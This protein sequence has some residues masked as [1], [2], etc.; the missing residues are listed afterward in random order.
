MLWTVIAGAAAGGVLGGALTH[1]KFRRALPGIILGAC[2]G[3]GVCHFAF[4]GP[5]P[6]TAAHTVDAFRAKVLHADKPVLVDFYA[7]WCPPCRQLSP[8]IEELAEEY[9]GRVK[10]VK[11][12]FDK[13]R[14]LAARYGV[15]G[16]PLVMFF[17]DGQPVGEVCG[18]HPKQ[19]YC[20]VLDLLLAQ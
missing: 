15:R 13:G 8:R 14:A 3:V 6:V 4:S 17:K 10:V 7:D 12:N 16:I 2:I 9:R 5:K 1:L 11:V 20:D 19:S 18:C